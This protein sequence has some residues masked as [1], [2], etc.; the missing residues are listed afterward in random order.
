M[1]TCKMRNEECEMR[2]A[3]NAPPLLARPA[4][5]AT[6]SFLISHFSFLI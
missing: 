5:I 1:R 2:N 6:P 3:L 4:D